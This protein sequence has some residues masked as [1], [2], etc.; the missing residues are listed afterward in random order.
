MPVSRKT[1]ADRELESPG[2]PA[3]RKRRQLGAHH[4]LGSARRFQ[5]SDSNLRNHGPNCVGDPRRPHLPRTP[6]ALAGQ[7]SQPKHPLLGSEHADAAAG[8][9]PAAEQRSCWPASCPTRQE[10]R[11]YVRRAAG[12]RRK[13][14]SPAGEGWRRNLS[15]CS[16]PGPGGGK[17]VADPTLVAE[18]ALARRE[19]LQPLAQARAQ[20]DFRA[21]LPAL[22]PL[23]ALR[24]SSGPPSWHRWRNCRWPAAQLLGNPG[25]SRLKTGISKASASPPYF[26]LRCVSALPELDCASY[27]PGS[28]PFPQPSD[29]PD[30]P[31]ASP[32]PGTLLAGL[33]VSMPKKAVAGTLGR[34]P[35]FPPTLGPA[36]SRTHSPGG[37]PA[38]RFRPSGDSP[39]MGPFTSTSRPCPVR[40]N[41]GSP[42]PAWEMPLS[43]EFTKKPEPVFWN[44]GGGQAKPSARRWQPPHRPR[45]DRSGSLFQALNPRAAW[46]ETG[47]RPNKPQLL[48][49]TSFLPLATLEL[50][51]LGAICRWRKLPAALEPAG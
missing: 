47:W 9:P 4:Q 29:L 42:G 13:Q 24:Q 15:R 25:R 7:H 22:P 39:R 30:A 36:I 33:G 17:R 18:L 8:G 43:M 11:R 12:R 51:L 20:A 27:P 46:A 14:A 44:P 49:S 38:S 6:A 31:P 28:R 32:L 1:C 5:C 26:L 50:A 10:Q 23:I 21:S 40:N 48:A 37:S 2:Q 45:P 41:N 34:H 35:V 3:T 16:A 19:R